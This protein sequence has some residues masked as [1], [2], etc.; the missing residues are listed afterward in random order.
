[1]LETELAKWNRQQ[2]SLPD[3][4]RLHFQAIIMTELPLAIEV[5][6]GKA[7]S[8]VMFGAKQYHPRC[9]EY[10]ENYQY[11]FHHPGAV[12]PWLM[13]G[14]AEAPMIN[15]SYIRLLATRRA[16]T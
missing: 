4:A 11:A 6:D 2:S 13:I 16:F 8:V 14:S 3:V 15:V 9:Q 12:H 5:K 10:G 1:V 7:V